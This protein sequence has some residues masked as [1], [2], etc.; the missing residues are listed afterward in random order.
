MRLKEIAEL[1]DGELV[2]DASIV[3]TGVAGIKEAKEGDITFLAHSRYLS[4]LE[5]T[6]ASAVIT[7]KE[8]SSAKKPL[9]RTPNPSQAFS[10]VVSSFI[11]PRFSQIAGIHPTAVVH[12]SAVLGR[13]VS[14]GP[15]AVVEKGSRIGDRSILQAHAFIGEDCRI[16]SDTWI[17]PQVTLY[18]GTQVGN[19]VLIHGGA[20]IGSDGFGYDTV[21]GRHHKIPHVGFVLIED[22]VEIGSN[23]SIDRGRFDKTWIKR[24]SKIDNLVQIGHNVVIGEDCLVVSQA[25]ISGSTELGRSVVVAGQAGVVGHITLGDGAV[26]GAGTG[27]TKSVPPHTVVLGNPAKPM[28]EGKRI[29]ALVS[30]LPELFKEVGEMKKKLG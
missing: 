21:D 29:L 11:P 22:D 4:F 3:I 23:V 2:G 14:V 1:V 18:P 15:Y 27:V 5:E 10:K 13:A 16:G 7:S 24:G 17:Y 28:R 20:V 6:A 12:E 19:R 26:V 9:I 8:I 30:R 25:G